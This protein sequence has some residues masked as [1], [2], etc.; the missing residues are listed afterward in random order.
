MSL[1][2]DP[3]PGSKLHEI[4]NESRVGGV[5]QA[6]PGKQL[7]GTRLLQA[8][9]SVFSYFGLSPQDF[10]RGIKRLQ[11]AEGEEG[12]ASHLFG[13]TTKLKGSGLKRFP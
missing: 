5:D 12:T 7:Q 4:Q 1:E 9:S 10:S 6:G 13:L 3:S 8:C 2:M 11:S